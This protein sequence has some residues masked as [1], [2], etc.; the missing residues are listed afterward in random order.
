MTLEHTTEERVRRVVRDIPAAERTGGLAVVAAL[1]AH[2]TDVVFGIPGT[3]N[4]EIYRHLPTLDVRAVTPR[5]EQGAGYAADGHHL[6]TGRPGVVLTTTGPALT[7][8]LTA[9]ATAHAESRPLL[10][11]SPGMPVGTEGMDLGRLH[12]TKDASGAAD[13]LMGSSRRVTTAEEAVDA[14]AEA[15]DG[16]ARRRPR[17]VHL[18]V[19]LDVLEGPW[20][21]RLPGLRLGGPAEL[22]PDASDEPVRTA[23]A[24]LAAAQ[25][26]LIVAGGGA[27]GAG[28]ALQ[29]LAERID[30]PVVTTAN[31]KGVLA[32]DHPLSLRADVRRAAVQ[33][34]SRSADVLMVVGSELGDSDLWGGTIGA[35]Y[36]SAPSRA[37]ESADDDPQTVIRLDVDPA[38]LHKNLPGDVV[39]AADAGAGL[40]ALVAEL[41][42]RREGPG[43]TGDAED[44]TTSAR[45]TPGRR[46]AA[47]LRGEVDEEFDRTATLP[48]ITTVVQ[49]AAGDDVIVAGD[50]SQVTYD[51]TIHALRARRE[52][53]L[54]YMPGHATLGYGIPAAIGAQIGVP[55]RPVVALVGDGAAMFTVQEV[56]T[57]VE[58]GLPVVI[59]I[60]DNGGYGEIEAQMRQI[61]V[62]PTGVRLSSPDFAALGCAMG[63]RGAAVDVSAEGWEDRLSAVVSEELAADGPTVV[64]LRL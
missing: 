18:E 43:T 2:G 49:Q 1:A 28:P 16:F 52:D 13:R 32:E 22:R 6:V 34:A 8:V 53:Q 9:A 30:A 59:I 17:P 46:R 29:A 14:V 54:L 31:G 4:L 61:G 27:R 56:A 24:R 55:D 36:G 3:H 63:A 58:Q 40:R 10:V 23:A 35:A 15:F 50:S 48:R 33:R 25:E 41:P 47:T 19:P 12:E 7:N 21:G 11:V 42:P 51:G 26:P 5:H 20:S 60:A 64:H 37:S 57:A 44:P 39:L 38:Q 62:E 45:T